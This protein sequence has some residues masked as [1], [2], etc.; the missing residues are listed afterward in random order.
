LLPLPLLSPQEL[1]KSKSKQKSKSRSK[2]KPESSK[3]TAEK[4]VKKNRKSNLKSKTKS[5]KV[6]AGNSDKEDK[7]IAR[8]KAVEGQEGGQGELKVEVVKK[9]GIDVG[10]ARTMEGRQEMKG[11]GEGEGETENAGEGQDEREKE[12]VGAREEQD[13]SDTS[14]GGLRAA[15]NA[16]SSSPSVGPVE[17]PTSKPGIRH[18]VLCTLLRSYTTSFHIAP[19]HCTVDHLIV[20][21]TAL[22]LRSYRSPTNH[23]PLRYYLILST[24]LLSSSHFYWLQIRESSPPPLLSYLPALSHTRDIYVDINRPPYRD[25]VCVPRAVCSVFLREGGE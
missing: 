17:A 10:G 6:R 14:W 12:G 4:N 5:S 15:A 3:K 20:S 13:L 18:L 23:L 22:I 24:L 8:E 19:S 25:S 21:K 11:D 2:S 7:G 1:S 9:G 16:T